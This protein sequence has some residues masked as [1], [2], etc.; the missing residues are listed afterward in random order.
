MNFAPALVVGLIASAIVDRHDR[1]LMMIGADAIRFLAVGA[2]LVLAMTHHLN[3]PILGVLLLALATGTTFFNSAIKALI[4]VSRPRRPRAFI[5]CP[6]GRRSP[7]F[8]VRARSRHSRD[9]GTLY[10]TDAGFLSS[11]DVRALK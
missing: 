9:S 1:R 11:L 3:A 5:A 6:T 2:I 10:C 4:P 8:P 7:R